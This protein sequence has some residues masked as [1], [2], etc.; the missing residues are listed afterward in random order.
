VKIAVI[1][2]AS[3]G[4]GK[5]FALRLAE[6]KNVEEVWVI[7]RREDRLKE[8]A[9]MIDKPVRILP[10]DLTKK[11]SLLEY[12]KALEE[13]DPEVIFLANCAGF[14]KFA[15]YT[16]VPLSESLNMI[17][18]N[19][20]ALVAVTELT[21]PYMPKGSSVIQLDSLSSFQPVPYITVYGATKAFVLSYSRAMN[22]E[23]KNRDIHMMAVC[24]GWVETEFFGRAMIDG[25]DSVNYFNI[26]YKPEDVV[27]TAIKDMY[28]RKKDVSIHGLP[29]KLQV[30]GV[31]LLP[32]S[33]IMKIWLKQQS[34]KK[35][36]KEDNR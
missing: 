30:L 6:D 16:N 31:K 26:L 17:D 35:S 28:K 5:E 11:S 18:L 34:G 13:A 19:V 33:L 15:R 3:S 32:H 7:A 14:G 10:L 27:N 8:L 20:K 22:V 29:V 21:L 9:D 23:L 2:G 25:D 12:G 4:M 36:K 1:T 24:P